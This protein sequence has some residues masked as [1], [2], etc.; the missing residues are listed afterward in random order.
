MAHFHRGDAVED[1]GS[2]AGLLTNDSGA[3]LKIELFMDLFRGRRDVYPKRFESKLTGKSGYQPSC[4]NEWIR[5]R[6]KKP[7]ISCN[8][9]NHRDFIPVTDDV[10][11]KH[12]L[13]Y[14]PDKK[15]RPNFTI[16]VYPLL[17][18]ETCWFIAADFDKA[19][20][21]PFEHKVMTRSTKFML[22]KQLLLK[23]SLSIQD[24]YSALILDEDRNKM[25]VE[26]VIGSCAAGRSPLVLTER[27]DHLE[28]LAGRIS[29]LAKNVVVMSGDMGLA[30]GK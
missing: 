28:W 26:D 22:P 10:I 30:S 5:S 27:K 3:E 9:C 12:L 23:D 25:I 18:D 29:K 16:G 24:I 14:D 7:R 13:G 15:S 1:S 6:C 19:S 20:W 11:K 21:R 4:R 17:P 8:S 2:A